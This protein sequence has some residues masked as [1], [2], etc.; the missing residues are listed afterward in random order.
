MNAFKGR[1]CS[2]FSQQPRAATA[3]HRGEAGSFSQTPPSSTSSDPRDT[4]SLHTIHLTSNPYLP[5]TSC[6][7]FVFPDPPR[8]QTSDFHSCG[9]HC[10]HAAHQAPT[11]FSLR[12]SN[13]GR[14]GVWWIL[15]RCCCLKARCWTGD[16][17]RGWGQKGKGDEHPA[18]CFTSSVYRLAS[19]GTA[20]TK[21]LKAS[22]LKL[23]KVMLFIKNIPIPGLVYFY[24]SV[25][26]IHK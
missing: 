24:I 21:H 20:Q 1:T 6:C 10:H 13:A 23:W 5:K 22:D 17:C 7:R 25:F 9:C 11:R 2:A 4:Q 16:S 8:G 26:F 19:E 12:R 18:W 3:T 15:P 14:D